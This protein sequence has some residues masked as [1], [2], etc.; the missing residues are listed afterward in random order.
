MESIHSPSELFPKELQAARESGNP[1]FVDRAIMSA[2]PSLR[3]RMKEWADQLVTVQT[4][5]EQG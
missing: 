3:G 4:E 5:E 2:N 1:P